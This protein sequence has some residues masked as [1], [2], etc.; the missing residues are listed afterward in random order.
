MKEIQGFEGLYSVTED[1]KVWAHEKQTRTPNGGFRKD[2][3]RWLTLSRVTKRTAHL[4]VYLHANGKT[5]GM[6]VHRL[7][8]MAYIPNPQNL[9]HINHIDCDPTNNSVTNLEW[10]NPVMN[11]KHAFSNGLTKAPQPCPGEKNGSAK[12]TEENV[13]EIRQASQNGES[14][15][16]IA[17]RYPVNAKTISDIILRKRWAHVI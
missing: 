2:G 16:S 6:L 1:G 5:I 9:P 3:G 11:G 8:A 10:C 15:A 17:K 4:R 14:G 13:K 7:V 12:L